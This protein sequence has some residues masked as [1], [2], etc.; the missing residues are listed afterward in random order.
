[1]SD[2]DVKKLSAKHLDRLRAFAEKM[3]KFGAE[4]TVFDPAGNRLTDSVDREGLPDGHAEQ[5]AEYA[6]TACQSSEQGVR[7][8]GNNGKFLA[9]CL[10]ENDE[11]VAVAVL[12]ANA[13]DGDTAYLLEMLDSLTDEFKSTSKAASQLEKVSTELLQTY[14]ELVLL[15]NM[16]TNM[17]VTQSNAI[18]LQMACDQLTQLVNVEGIAIFLERTENGQQALALTA[19][20][21]VVSIDNM[22]AD[23][24]QVRLGQELDAGKEALLDSQVDAPFKYDWP[25][26]IENLIAVPLSGN[27][28]MF[29]LMVA[30]NVVEKPDFDSTDIKLFNSVANQCAV[31]IENCRLFKDL[32]ELFIGSLKTLTN[33]IDAKDQYTRGHSERVAFISRWIAEKVA[34]VEPLKEEE[35]HKIYLAGL[36]HDIGKIGVDEAV[37]RKKG[38]LNDEEMSKIKTHPR[39]GAAIL[40]DIRQMRDIV[41]G[42][43]YHH[44]RMD[45]K[46]YPEGLEGER[47]PLIGKIISLADAFDAMTSKR[48]Y[49]DAMSIK[50]ATAE[51]EKTLGTQFDEKIGNIFLKSD[52]R[53]LWSIIQDGFI[54]SWDYSNFSEYGTTA[55]GALIR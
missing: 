16:S 11:T 20:S 46:G 32:K 43:L 31:F 49:R 9:T 12:D 48:T 27:G 2:T 33:S 22:T 30:T 15:Y 25:E 14:E 29:G 55:V 37:L 24:L 53:K 6:R 7:H 17:K 26:R 39:I 19:G 50:R 13:A 8:C 54:E 45:G 42:V 4:L 1:M 5:L 52:I 38:K 41:P 47:I 36:L 34:E 21:G 10:Q 35:I 40:A 28:R 3:D 44:E 23:V 18:Y 51:I